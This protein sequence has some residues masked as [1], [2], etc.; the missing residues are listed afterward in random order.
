MKAVVYDFCESRAGEHARAIL[1]D[2]KGALVCDDFSGYKQ[3]FTLGV[4][5][6]GCMAH[7]QRKF[8]ELHVSNKSQIARQALGYISALYDVEREVK[9]LSTNERLRMRQAKSRPL[10]DALYQSMVLQRRQITDG[11][12]TARALERTHALSR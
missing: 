7:S 8:L 2:W 1:A 10:A 9:S 3:S 4:A 11:S 6:A 12:A 5:K